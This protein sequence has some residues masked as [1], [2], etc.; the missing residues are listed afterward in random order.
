MSFGSAA[1]VIVLVI[2]IAAVASSVY[3]VQTDGQAVIKRFGRVVSIKPPGL[4]F[5][6]PFGIDRDTFIPTERVLKEEF[7]FRIFV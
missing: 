7:G 4:H 2:A 5:K 6:L 1:I 3:S